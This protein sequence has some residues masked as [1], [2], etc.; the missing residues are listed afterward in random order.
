MSA[1][2]GSVQSPEHVAKRVASFQKT[3]AVRYADKCPRG[4]LFEEVGTYITPKG[5][6]RCRGCRLHYH[7]LHKRN[8]TLS[9]YGLNEDSFK[10]M[11]AK[12][13]N[14]CAICGILSPGYTGWVVDHDHETG[15]VRGILCGACNFGLGNFKDDTLLLRRA[16]AYLEE[17]RN[18]G[19]A[20]LP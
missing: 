9:Q 2:R 6:R 3:W 10:S 17:S 20:P 8:H 7:K 12:Q 19:G 15:V 18:G 4:H 1:K 14:A 11:L 13:G 16:L 5:Q